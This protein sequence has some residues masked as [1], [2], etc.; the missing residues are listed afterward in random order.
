MEAAQA[1]YGNPLYRDALP[2]RLKR[3]DY[4]VFIVEGATK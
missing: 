2:H 3:A 4:S 1:K